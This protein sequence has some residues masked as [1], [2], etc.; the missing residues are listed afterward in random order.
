[1]CRNQKVNTK[2]GV[3]VVNPVIA[4]WPLLVE[5]AGDFAGL[6]PGTLSNRGEHDATTERAKAKEE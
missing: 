6:V 1:M 4:F 5:A 2:L 3:R